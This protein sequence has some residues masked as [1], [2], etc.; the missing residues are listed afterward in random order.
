M[1]SEGYA[2]QTYDDNVL[3]VMLN[4]FSLHLTRCRFISARPTLDEVVLHS[5]MASYTASTIAESAVLLGPSTHDE[6]TWL[7]WC[8]IVCLDLAFMKGM[9]MIC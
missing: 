1:V 6:R 2:C 8:D 9:V 3:R 4:V 5:G 7:G